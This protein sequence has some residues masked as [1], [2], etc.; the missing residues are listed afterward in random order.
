M[1]TSREA[2]IRAEGEG[3]QFLIG[4]WVITTRVNGQE[5]EGRF[6]MYH[7]ALGPGSVDYHVHDIADETIHILEGDI[8]VMKDGKKSRHAPGSTVFVPMGVHHGF[9]NVGTGQARVLLVFSPSS[10]QN[11][12]F[13]KVQELF[14]KPSPDMKELARLQDEYDQ[15]LIPFPG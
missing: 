3:Q 11:E 10:R 2:F 7:L 8:E 9:T 12:F 15:K 4:N 1:T 5:S 13:A 14:S 6:E